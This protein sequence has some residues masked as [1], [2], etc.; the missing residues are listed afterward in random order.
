[1]GARDR[2]LIDGRYGALGEGLQ[3][4]E[5][6]GRSVGLHEVL[7]LLG[8]DYETIRAIDMAAFPDEG[9]FGIRYVDLEDRM[10]VAFEFTAEFRY[11]RERRAHLAEWMGDEAYHQFPWFLACP[12]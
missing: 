10:I 2:Q 1:M 12:E 7:R 9:V 8:Q 5:V 11:V 3:R 6:A 4:L